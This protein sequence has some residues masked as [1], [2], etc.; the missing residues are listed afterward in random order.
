MSRQGDARSALIIVDVQNDFCPGGALAAPGG[1][2]IVP[3]LNK[4]IEEARANGMPVYASRDW[5]PA[6]TTHFQAYGGPWPPHC[7]AGT[8]GAAFHPALELPAD[9]IVISKGDVPD[10]AG[11]SA[12]DGRTA[13]GRPLVDD[14]RARGI[15]RLYV[16]GLT[17]EYCVKQ[18]VLDGLR[19]GLRVDVLDDA[20]GG[21]NAAPGD[22]ER[23]LDEMTA[24]GAR[25]SHNLPAVPAR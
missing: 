12:F 19:A 15:D 18:T 1:D 6:V 2:R 14:L 11:Y 25:R 3:A 7:V 21:L 24:A 9:A 22:A 5:H 4:Y 8:P 10:K 13:A 17:A 23:A 16:A 20:V